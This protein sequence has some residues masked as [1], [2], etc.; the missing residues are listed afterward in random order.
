VT[1]LDVYGSLFYAGAQTL[2][3]KLPDPTGATR[4]V[5]VLRLRGRSSLGATF[6][7]VIDE[8]ADRLHQAGGRLYLSGVDPDMMTMLERTNQINGTS[9]VRAFPA[10]ATVG[11]ASAAAA[12]AATTWLITSR[13]R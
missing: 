1:E 13:G 5:V 12:E 9:H 4:P 3:A 10:T 6:V 7:S 11:E 2:R 8:Y